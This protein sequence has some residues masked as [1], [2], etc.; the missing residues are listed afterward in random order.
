LDHSSLLDRVA[1]EHLWCGIGEEVEAV[2][3]LLFPR[4]CPL[5]RPRGC[6]K[7]R[8]VACGSASVWGRRGSGQ[9]RMREGCPLHQTRQQILPE[10]M[11]AGGSGW[12][13]FLRGAGHARK[14]VA[15]VG[16]ARAKCWKLKAA[17]A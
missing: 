7:A 11:A 2:G 10:G 15:R 17:A 14:R 3:V 13:W 6:A 1:R 9:Q 16:A 12:Q 4:I 5:A 8:W